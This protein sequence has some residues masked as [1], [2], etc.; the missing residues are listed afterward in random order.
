MRLACFSLPDLEDQAR[1][2]YSCRL[3]HPIPFVSPTHSPRFQA[4]A[5]SR[6]GSRTSSCRCRRRTYK[7]RVVGLMLTGIGGRDEH[8]LNCLS[9]PSPETAV[10]HLVVAPVLVQDRRQNSA[11][12][13]VLD[14]IVAVRCG[15]ALPVPLHA[16]SV[17]WIAV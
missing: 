8:A 10:A 3:P 15:V 13:E 1:T 16:L 11:R 4:P 9:A 2:L 12:H 14:Q 17:R 5:C 7:F 6:G